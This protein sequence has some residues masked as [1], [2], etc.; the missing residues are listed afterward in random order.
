MCTDKKTFSIYSIL[1]TN[2]YCNIFSGFES[3]VDFSKHDKHGAEKTMYV[4]VPSL[5]SN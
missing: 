1:K 3:K 4:T 5:P 2:K